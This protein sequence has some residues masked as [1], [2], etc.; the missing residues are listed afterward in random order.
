MGL[1]TYFDSL[2]RGI[3][4]TDRYNCKRVTNKHNKPPPYHISL[5]LVQ[6]FAVTCALIYVVASLRELALQDS[7][8]YVDCVCPLIVL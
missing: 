6:M 1:G 8:A 2:G 3:A 7:G 5:Q 4:G